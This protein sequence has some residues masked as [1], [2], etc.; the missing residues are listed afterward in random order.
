[1]K[2]KHLGIAL[3]IGGLLSACGG[4]SGATSSGGGNTPVS[5]TIPVTIDAMTTM[6]VINGGATRGQVYVYNS[7]DVQITGLTYQLEKQTLKSSI[8]SMLQK[9]GISLNGA[10][11]DT[12]GFVLNDPEFCASIPAHSSCAINFT[13]PALS[14]GNQ[15]GSRVSV[16]YQYN[17]KS[18]TSS[19]I[20][21]YRYTDVS[22]VSGVNFA[23]NLNLK[24]QQNQHLRV[25]GFMYAGGA[26]TVRYNN[27]ILK[28]SNTTIVATNGFSN[29]Q[30]VA[31]GQV[32]PV[33]FDVPLQDSRDGFATITPQWGNTQKLQQ[34]V[35]QSHS[36]QD[37]STSGV[38]DP[39]RLVLQPQQNTVN[40]MFSYIPLLSVATGTA[41][42]TVT[43]INNGNANATNGITAT[44]TSGDT[45]AVQ[46]N[47]T[48][49]SS[50][51]LTAFGGSSCTIGITVSTYNSGSAAITF[52]SNG[53]TVGTQEIYW[54]NST[55]YPLVY[56]TSSA[57][58]V[59][60]PKGGSSGLITFT[61]TN[62]GQAPLNG[63]SH[64]VTT[65]LPLATW[66]ESS[67]NCASS[68]AP[69]ASCTITGVLNGNTDGYAK[70]S[71]SLF[72]NYNSVAYTYRS[73]PVD[74]RVDSAAVLSINPT[75]TQLKLLAN[76]VE[77]QSK[78]YTV[79]NT[80]TVNAILESVELSAMTT[81]V[82]PVIESNACSIG[83]LLQPESTCTI[84]VT[85]G[86]SPYTE[87]ANESGT[88]TLNVGYH[89]G[90]PDVSHVAKSVINY[91]LVGNDAYVQVTAAV[92]NYTGSGTSA[93]PYLTNYSLNSQTITLTY[94]NMS[95]NY[96]MRGF[97]LNTQA[98]PQVYS[99]TGTC[100]V[101]SNTVLLGVSE[102]CTLILT[103]ASDAL[104][105][106]FL[107]SRGISY[108]PNFTVTSSW[109]T[110]LGFYSESQPIVYVTYTQ[111][112]VNS[113]LTPANGS[114]ESTVL[115][116][117]ATNILPSAPVTLNVTGVESWLNT[118][119]TNLSSN[120]TLG[121]ESSI[122]CALTDTNSNGSA[123]YV[124][125]DG[126]NVGD[127]AMIPLGFTSTPMVYLNPPYLWINYTK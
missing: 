29:G 93:D 75:E 15:D 82:Q 84:L 58:S 45:S 65:N 94:T 21:N 101:G 13:T 92:S 1:M 121:T 70:L 55:P 67:N 90:T 63:V 6:P 14:V 26:S 37:A 72:G 40:Y 102:S 52:T 89:G 112:S 7:S 111:P 106:E 123:T 116:I 103:L 99:Q 56:I 83:L 105:K 12:K 23:G 48:A 76:G 17:G 71:A 32:V 119:P 127:N 44:A 62:I 73:L 22:A 35:L 53:Y 110:P 108:S 18:V 98:I 20:V 16:N 81:D 74:Y 54:Y 113:F 109:T 85:Y 79:T 24:G 120:C 107:A 66:V 125:N 5:N 33:E 96:S 77:S 57:T 11:I 91:N 28:P 87:S 69:S 9:I 47:D 41:T 36:L 124:M 31:G 100:P 38:G 25:V 2:I 80:G 10:T 117:S 60:L 19:Q 51:N 43:V 122:S 27:V 30:Q 39:L 118:A 114:F 50:A 8:R 59:V 78:L 68:L 46:I 95:E 97:S 42:T 64:A 104:S 49:C 61:A 3:A 86:P 126:F 115:S 34:T 4:S 88:T